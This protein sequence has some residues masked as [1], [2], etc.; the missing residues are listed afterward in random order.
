MFLDELMWDGK[1]WLQLCSRTVRSML[2]ERDQVNGEYFSRPENFR[3]KRDFTVR[4]LREMFERYLLLRDRRLRL[5]PELWASRTP[6][7][8][9]IE[10]RLFDHPAGGAD[11]PELEDWYDARESHMMVYNYARRGKLL[12]PRNYVFLSEIS[13]PVLVQIMGH[14]SELWSGSE[15]S[16]S[17]N[18]VRYHTNDRMRDELTHRMRDRHEALRSW[19][20]AFWLSGAPAAG[21]PSP[22]HRD[23]DGDRDRVRCLSLRYYVREALGEIGMEHLIPSTD[24]HRA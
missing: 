22:A 23:G 19:V 20:V 9:P 12:P 1:L 24:D 16:G 11:T 5:G 17:L 21:P 13:S 2:V 7:R 8:M 3:H 18:R 15:W 6:S 4:R 14:P 10:L